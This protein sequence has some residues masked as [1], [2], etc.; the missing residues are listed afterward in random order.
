MIHDVRIIPL[1]GRPHP[2]V[3]IREWMGDGRGHWEGETLVVDTTNFSEKSNF[4]GSSS[5]LHLTE[6][7]TRMDQDTI[8]Y[9][10]HVEDPTTFVKPWSAEMPL[11][12]ID[13]PIIEYACNEGNYAMSGLL[14]GARADEKKEAE[15][16][17]AEKTAAAKK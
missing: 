6:R 9:E 3:E 11:N 4:R 10:F 5:G 2:P 14:G 13:S 16:K 1:D 15:K 7:F 8:K 17:E 12:K